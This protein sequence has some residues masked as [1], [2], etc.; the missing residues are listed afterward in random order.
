ML[1]ILND[2][3]KHAMLFAGTA[4]L[5]DIKYVARRFALYPFCTEFVTDQ[6][7]PL[8]CGTISESYV[9]RGLPSHL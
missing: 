6:L 1:K 4:C 2:E 8:W 7:L 5:A 9:R 3:L